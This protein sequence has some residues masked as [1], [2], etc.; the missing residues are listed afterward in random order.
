MYVFIHRQFL[1]LIMY[2]IIIVKCVCDKMIV[3]Q[4]FKVFLSKL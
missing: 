3:Q 1:F 2:G 4:F